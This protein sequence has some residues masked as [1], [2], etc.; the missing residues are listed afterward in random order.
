MSHRTLHLF[1]LVAILFL[2]TATRFADIETR[3]LWEDEGW[4]LLL[5]EGPTLPDI[6]TRLANDQHP[7]LFFMIF[8]IWRDLTGSTEFAMRVLPAFTGVMAVAGVYQ[9][10]KSMFGRNAGLL[11][12]FALAIADHHID[13]SQD[14]RHYSQMAT[15]I[16][17]SSW[18]YFRLIQSDKPS[19]GTRMGYVL[20]SAAALYT[21]YLTG[22]VIIVQV[23]HMLLFVRPFQRLVWTGFHWAAACAL[24]L[25]WLPTVLEQN[26]VRWDTPL[27]Y[28]N[29]LAN[30]PQTVRMVRDAVLGQQYAITLTLIALGL[31]YLVYAGDRVKINFR[32]LS[33][34]VFAVIWLGGYVAFTFWYNDY[35]SDTRDR[36]F[37]TTRNFLVVTPAVAILVGHGLANM[38]LGLRT[39]LVG[40]LLV[41]GLTTTDVRQLKPPWREVTQNVT[42]FH[43]PGEPV[44][45]DIWVG[46]FSTRYYVEQQMG[47]DT[48]WL[49][50]RETADQQKTLFLPY[51]KN[52]IQDED[53]FWLIYWGD[54]PSRLEYESIFAQEGF[55]RTTSPYVVH[56]GARLYSHRYDRITEETLTTYQIEG[57]DIFTLQKAAIQGET[58][59]GED[60][61]VTLWWT[62]A[63]KPPLDFSVSVFVIGEDGVS[64]ANSD[65]PPLDGEAMTST[66]EVGRLQ[67]D[68]HDLSLPENLP[69]GRYDIGVK[70]YYYQ[71]PEAP[72]QTPCAD[73]ADSL[74][75]WRVIEQFVVE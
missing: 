24:F 23:I 29:A 35:L 47:A 33:P 59:P 41:V 74:C 49:S 61:I 26:S 55:Q 13:L 69:P 9:L 18:F 17:L 7:P 66:W 11:A 70:V 31:V 4:T 36:L 15:M 5:A 58:Q 65:G 56:E 1:A 52:Y 63:V 32:P 12:A 68:Q 46:D 14:V 30:S 64:V 62:A 28:L 54:D 2:A 67:Y 73:D 71:A 3:S 45:M 40:V 16:V 38:Q 75:D 10:G 19:W 48:P 43:N 8:H 21:H 20:L 50:I 22:F 42:E 51:I 57:E 53:A 60:F 34:T 44:L 6:V 37:L 25:P 27:Y 39:F 72:L